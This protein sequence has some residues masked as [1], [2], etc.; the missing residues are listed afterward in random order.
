MGNISPGHTQV[1]HHAPRLPGLH[2]YLSGDL[3]GRGLFGFE[4]DLCL[5]IHMYIVE[6]IP[7]K[8]HRF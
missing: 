3:L 7:L 2:A 4:V 1:H 6:M 8:S 5:R